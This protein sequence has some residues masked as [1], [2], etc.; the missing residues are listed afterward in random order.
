MAE[1]RLGASQV[2]TRRN[3]RWMAVGVLAV[4]LGGLGAALLYANL[5]NAHTVL[6]VKRTVYRD[7][8]ITAADLG[9]T[10]AVP[11]LGVETLPSDQLDTVVGLTALSDLVEGSLLSPRSFGE[12]V[13]EAGSVRIGLRLAAGRLPSAAMPPGTEVLLVPVGRDGAEPP[14]GASVTARI[15]TAAAVLP[16]GA[17][18]VDVSVPAAEGERVVRLAANEQLALVRLPGGPR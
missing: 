8:V 9:A 16:D 5:S 3:L 14:A 2:R 12:P 6:V 4:C 18:I 15:A 7:Q 17:S 1:E 13:V 11:A 10:S